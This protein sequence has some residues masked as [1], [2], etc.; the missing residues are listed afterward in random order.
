V[1][2]EI[3][4]HFA[5]EHGYKLISN[6][7]NTESHSEN[8]SYLIQAKGDKKRF[9]ALFESKTMAS[10]QKLNDFVNKSAPEVFKVDPAFARNTDLI[11]LHQLDHRADFKNIENEVFNIEENPYYFKKYFLYYS[12]EELSLLANQNFNSLAQVVIDEKEFA[13][14][15]ET[16]LAPSL[17]SIAARLFIKVPFIKVPIKEGSLKPIQIYLDEALIEKD[18]HELYESIL[19]KKSNNEMPDEIIRSLINEEMEGS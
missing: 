2:R 6:D 18:V 7:T 11:I 19:S 10:P 14:Y 3:I 4:E 13:E 8:L 17:Y 5:I 16:P 12:E 1:I 9:L 15:R